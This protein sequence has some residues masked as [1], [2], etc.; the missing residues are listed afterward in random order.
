MGGAARVIIDAE[1]FSGGEGTRP[2][3][4]Y[5]DTGMSAAPDAYGTARAAEPSRSSRHSHHGRG[6]N[7]RQHS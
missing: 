6:R 2:M 4:V 3:I 5:A 7:V 1:T